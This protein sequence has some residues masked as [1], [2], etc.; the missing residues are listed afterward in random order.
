MSLK[1]F[2][3]VGIDVGTTSMHLSVS[4]IWLANV[5]KAGEPERLVITRLEAI[6]E[7]PVCLTPLCGDG[8]IDASAIFT[9]VQEQYQLAGLDGDGIAS[10]AVIV[11]GETAK[12]RNAE[13][14]VEKL[15]GLAGEFVAASAGP[16]FESV[17]AGRGSGAGAYSK[18]Y[19][20]II[21]NV[22]VGGGTTNIAIFERGQI[23]STSAVSLGGRL[24]CL[25]EN[26][27]ILKISDSAEYCCG[28]LNISARTGDILSRE[29]AELLA[30]YAARTIVDS[31]TVSQ[32]THPLL[33]TEPLQIDKSIDE[34]WFS[35]GVAELM[36]RLPGE[37]SGTEY[38]DLGN[39]LAASLVRE[40]SSRSIVYRIP[41]SPIRATVKGASIHSV[42]VTGSTVFYEEEGLPLR[43]LPVVE[44]R[45]HD[46]GEN[47]DVPKTDQFARRL[48]EI[49]ARCDVDWR[50]GPVALS[51]PD[52]G[53]L[54]YREATRWAQAINEVFVDLSGQP[55]LVVLCS[56]DVA[57]ALGQCLKRL[58][59]DASI[60]CVDGVTTTDLSHGQ[61]VDI[62]R[63]MPGGRSLPVVV[64]TMVFA[65]SGQASRVFGDGR[66]SPPAGAT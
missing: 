49:L 44:Y 64:R 41:D 13:A 31:L 35:G 53:R 58:N 33:L 25:S 23:A 8:T 17:L 28:M 54:G 61:Y 43:C 21:C 65:G 39:F 37:V 50:S 7:S 30:G 14:V 52:L 51:L 47:L 27:K 1:S 5:S 6:Y 20:K 9:F 45:A 15:S 48:R 16:N 19:D 55:P 24:I 40:L 18:E 56:H 26:K 22:D 36:M 11:T 60:V 2:L 46:C 66:S 12:I 34:F 63:P 29:S 10:G 32:W 59:P 3:S 62:G 57:S 38:G 42:Q 4:R